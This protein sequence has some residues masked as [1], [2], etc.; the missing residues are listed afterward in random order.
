M[1]D[2]ASPL[3]SFWSLCVLLHR[4]LT[5]ASL[6]V[7]QVDVLLPFALPRGHGKR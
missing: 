1:H 4:Q 3:A 7:R 6:A 2:I 5:S